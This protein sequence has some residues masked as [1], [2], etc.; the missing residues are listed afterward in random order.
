MH[1]N[2]GIRININIKKDWNYRDP[3]K[4]C[5]I[6]KTEDMVDNLNVYLKVGKNFK[7]FI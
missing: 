2:N 7:I 5:K 6:A 4:Y 1:V 3:G